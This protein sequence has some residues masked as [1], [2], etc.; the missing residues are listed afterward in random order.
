MANI[1]VSIDKPITDGSKLKFR[2]PCDST[3]VEGLEVKYPA[4]NGVGTL[5]KKFVFKDA[6]GTE[7][8]GCGNLFFSGVMIEVLLDVVHGVAYIKN[9]DTNSY[10]EK[11]KNDVERLEESQKQFLKLVGG[12]VAD[13]ERAAKAVYI[14]GGEMPEDAII[15]IDPDGEVMT[16]DTEVTKGSQNP[17]ASNAVAVALEPINEEVSQKANTAETIRVYKSLARLGLVVGEETIDAIA[18]SMEIHSML[19]ISIGTSNANIYPEP[20]PYGSLKVI[21]HD[22]SR[23][24]FQ[25]T[26]KVDSTRWVG[27]YSETNTDAKW[28]GWKR[29]LTEDD[30]VDVRSAECATSEKFNGKTVYT[31][32]VEVGNLPNDSIKNVEHGVANVGNFVEIKGFATHGS[33][34]ADL[35]SIAM[36]QCTDTNLR[37]TTDYD[38]S[39]Y[40]GYVTLKYTKK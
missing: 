38:Y 29:F 2:T 28:T 19:V 31:K 25:Y 10:V 34:W 32:L 35:S 13:C 36:L 16:I 23:V 11:V 40:V 15:Q 26:S 12:T 4:K 18:N 17:V 3:T 27:N 33:V 14:G 9:A 22:K 5:I 24:V 39:N 1:H 37:V 20:I 30:L 7:L 8:S 21:C 6:H